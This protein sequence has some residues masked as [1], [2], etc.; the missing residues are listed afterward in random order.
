MMNALRD[1]LK[2]FRFFSNC[3]ALQI[4]LT[5]HPPVANFNR[6]TADFLSPLCNMHFIIL[7]M[8][9]QGYLISA[10]LFF[11]EYSIF[12]SRLIPEYFSVSIDARY[13]HNIH[14]TSIFIYLYFNCNALF[15]L[16]RFF[17]Y[18]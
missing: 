6:N 2:R 4:A 12:A 10:Y 18:L 7:R 1:R 15:F 17:F 13:G 8:I 16:I 11:Y 14:V 9:L 3:N 5:N